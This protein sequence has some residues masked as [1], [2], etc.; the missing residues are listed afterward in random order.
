MHANKVHP[1]TH[2]NRRISWLPLICVG[3]ML[4]VTGCNTDSELNQIGEYVEPAWMSEV[5]SERETDLAKYR[6]CLEAAGLNYDVAAN[7]GVLPVLPDGLSQEL[8]DLNS[9]AIS[10]CDEERIPLSFDA[11]TASE[12][13]GRMIETRVCLV[14]QGFPIPEPP[15]EE[16]WVEHFKQLDRNIFLP[17][18]ELDKL[19]TAGSVDLT[20][21]QLGELQNVCVATAG[22]GAIESYSVNLD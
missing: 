16:V 21:Q 8:I 7:G 6:T 15:S 12:E 20:E 22:G 17:Y 14:S 19:I 13:Y 2:P 18:F 10:K 3:V 1:P 4:T 9:F 5:R 11:G